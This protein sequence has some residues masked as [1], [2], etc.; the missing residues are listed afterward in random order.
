MCVI[1]L[2]TGNTT[3]QSLLGACLTLVSV[4]FLGGF[5]T[6]THTQLQAQVVSADQLVQVDVEQALKCLDMCVFWSVNIKVVHVYVCGGRCRPTA[7]YLQTLVLLVS[8][9]AR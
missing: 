9:L 7:L 6:H 4:C 1:T 8:M 2:V 3:K 5:L